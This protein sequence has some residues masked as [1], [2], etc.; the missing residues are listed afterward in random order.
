MPARGVNEGT[1]SSRN[2]SCFKRNGVSH[3]HSTCRHTGIRQ[4]PNDR[5][6]PLVPVFNFRCSKAPESP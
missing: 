5:G 2:A 3:S 1:L 4:R 6:G